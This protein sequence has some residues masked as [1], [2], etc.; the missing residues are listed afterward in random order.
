MNKTKDREQIIS[1]ICNAAKQY[2]Q[3]LIGKK[4]L[5]IFE[6]RSIEIVF[7]KDSFKH[8]TGVSSY[9]SAKQFYKK[10]LNGT[11]RKEQIWFVHKDEE[12]VYLY[13]LADFTTANTGIRDS[14]NLLDKYKK[15]VLGALPDPSFF[16]SL[17]EIKSKY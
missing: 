11:L 2:K 14:T 15:G 7:K 6:S 17:L 12:Q 16:D 3:N 9:L 13:S 4:F 8:L 10:A 5:F 1:A